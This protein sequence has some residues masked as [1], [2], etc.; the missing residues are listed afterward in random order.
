MRRIWKHLGATA[1]V[2][3][4]R[5][6]GWVVLLAAVAGCHDYR[7]NWDFQK[8]EDIEAVERAAREKNKDL[9]IFYKG[10]F[11][12][13]S[14]YMHNEVLADNEVGALFQDTVNVL[15]DQL[16][17]PVFEEYMRSRYGV[18]EPPAFV[19]VAPDG[20][21][22]TRTGRMQK[23]EFVEWVKRT[24]SSPPAPTEKPKP[25]ASVP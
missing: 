5:R 20:T 16:G 8:T 4:C 6:S 11:D 24:K 17:G 23:P 10:F 7:W 18:S 21:F 1:A 19:L 9:F 3:R 14:I 25:G 12:N 22:E 2:G 15:L 13:D